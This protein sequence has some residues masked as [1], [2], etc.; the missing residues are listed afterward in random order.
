[1][2]QHRRATVELELA[3]GAFLELGDDVAQHELLR[4]FFFF[5]LCAIDEPKLRLRG[6]EFRDLL[7]DPLERQNEVDHA[8]RE[9][10][11][12]HRVVLGLVGVLHDGQAATFFDL[13]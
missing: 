11:A 3:L 9:R 7:G 8:G 13:P 5:F 12:R 10:V 2:A 1:M 4:L 6:A